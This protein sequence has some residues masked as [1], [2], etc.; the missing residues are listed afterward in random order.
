MGVTCFRHC[1]RVWYSPKI[2]I[3]AAWGVYNK[4]AY[5]KTK[6]WIFITKYTVI[7]GSLKKMANFLL[8]KIRD[9]SHMTSDR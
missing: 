8:F 1:L 9:R 6:T 5:N 2:P 7:S 4:C 3:V